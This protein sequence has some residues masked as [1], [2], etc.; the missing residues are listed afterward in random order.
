MTTQVT[1]ETVSPVDSDIAYGRTIDRALAHRSAISEVF[2]TDVRALGPMAVTAGIHLP[3]THLYYSDHRQRP[4]LH[5]SLLFLEAGRQVAI[6]GSHTHVGIPVE[7]IAIVNT[8]RFALRN[9]WALRIGDEPGAPRIDTVFSGTPT[10]RSGRYRKGRLV[11]RL[12]MGDVHIGDHSMDV[13]FLK[14]HENDLLRHAQRGSAAPLTSE[15]AKDA[16]PGPAGRLLPESV[17]RGNPLNVVLADPEVTAGSVTARVVPRFDNP[18]LFDH[19]Y[20]HLPA[21]ALV[22][23]ARQAAI[24]AAGAGTTGPGAAQAP[25]PVYAAGFEAEFSRFAELD[26]PLSVTA[27]RVPP[28]AARHDVRVGFR[29]GA[30]D[31]AALTV[32]VVDPTRP[33]GL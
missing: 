4:R 9:L 13:Q 26:L 15:F 29:Q 21:M 10:R 8:F 14:K 27:S 11:Q 12:F 23:A 16:G 28:G 31:I 2:V 20:D 18:A 7:T 1:E 22:E 32:T 25:L 5:D 24:L 33:F 3:L 6:A 17:G 30:Q 19:A